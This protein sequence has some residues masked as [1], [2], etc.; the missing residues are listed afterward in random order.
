MEC[1]KNNL[2][3]EIKSSLQLTVHCWKTFA[4]SFFLDWSRSA[5]TCALS[6]ILVTIINNF[7][8]SLMHRSIL[9]VLR[10]PQIL[11]LLVSNLHWKWVLTKKLVSLFYRSLGTV[12]LSNCPPH[13]A[14]TQI[15]K[16]NW[17]KDTAWSKTPSFTGQQ[18]NHWESE[19]EQCGGLLKTLI[20]L[21]KM[22]LCMVTGHCMCRI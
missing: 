22:V 11:I 10:P 12:V 18:H 7:I 13:T 1:T 6:E 5:G 9:K 21:K 19:F 20:S 16:P 2:F 17:G 8:L 15:L 14:Q 4:N 3:F